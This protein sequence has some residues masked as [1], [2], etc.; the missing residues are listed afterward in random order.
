M[1][2]IWKQRMVHFLLVGDRR[3]ERLDTSERIA[4]R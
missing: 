4:G 2:T 1:A 3:D